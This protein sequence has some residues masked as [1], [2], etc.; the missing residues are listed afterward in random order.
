VDSHPLKRVLIDNG[1]IIIVISSM[2]LERIK[3]PIKFLNAPTL[4]IRDFNNTLDMKMG[5]FI[6]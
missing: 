5:T 4:I 1:S 2:E 6:L 3:V